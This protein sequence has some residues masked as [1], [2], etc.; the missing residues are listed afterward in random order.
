MFPSI[1]FSSKICYNTLGDSCF[2]KNLLSM[3]LTKVR[4][5]KIDRISIRLDNNQSSELSASIVFNENWLSVQ[6]LFYPLTSYEGR[7]VLCAI[8]KYL[9]VS[10]MSDLIGKVVWTCA[11]NGVV[12]AICDIEE[13]KPWLYLFGNTPKNVSPEDLIDLIAKNKTTTLSK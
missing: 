2:M 5:K 8:M 9:D 6:T 4:T 7:Y 13:K 10:D 11:E 1:V 3:E 12:Y